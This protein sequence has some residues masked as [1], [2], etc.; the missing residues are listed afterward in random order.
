MRYICEFKGMI[1]IITAKN[2]NEAS[3]IITNHVREPYG[4]GLEIEIQISPILGD[5]ELDAID[6][7]REAVVKLNKTTGRQAYDYAVERVLKHA[8]NISELLEV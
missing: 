5:K 2:L 4:Y 6:E 7:L 3:V 1:K 8:E